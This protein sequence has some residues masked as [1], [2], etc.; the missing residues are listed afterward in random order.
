MSALRGDIGPL[1][2]AGTPVYDPASGLVFAVAG[3][4]GGTHLL[5]GRALRPALKVRREV[6]PPR[7]TPIA[8][9]QR[10]A[11]TLYD[12]RVYIAFGGLDGDCADYIGGVVSVA[13]SRPV[14][15]SRTPLTPK[16]GAWGPAIVAVGVSRVA[17]A[18]NRLAHQPRRDRAHV[19]PAQAKA[20]GPAL[21]SG[22]KDGY[23]ASVK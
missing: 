4:T 15:R 9:Q 19:V 10:P 5:A 13:T 11:L 6:E 12:G 8:T 7:G 1:G 16:T 17:A 2:I 14:L 23:D 18:I 21:A 3:T 20:G 22:I